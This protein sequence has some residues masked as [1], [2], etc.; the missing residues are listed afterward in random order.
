M[1]YKRERLG[2]GCEGP[3]TSMIVVYRRER[4]AGC[5]PVKRRVSREV[6]QRQ[7]SIAYRMNNRGTTSA[8]LEFR[9][10]LHR[11]D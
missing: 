8:A 7:C 9:N 6:R 3:V 5:G 2:C 1:V 4:L 11:L 10:G